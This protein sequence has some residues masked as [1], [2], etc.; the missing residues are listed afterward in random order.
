MILLK[1]LIFLPVL[2]VSFFDSKDK[3]VSLLNNRK[4]FLGI[5]INSHADDF[6]NFIISNT[7]FT[8]YTINTSHSNIRSFENW[9]GSWPT[10]YNGYKSWLEHFSDKYV[11]IKK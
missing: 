8:R 7:K 11:V 2:W 4:F 5:N 3:L 6:I 1:T 9:G 10:G